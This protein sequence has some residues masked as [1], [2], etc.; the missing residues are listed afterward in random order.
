V[1]TADDLSE[2]QNVA[3]EAMCGFLKSGQGLLRV[4]GYAGT[5]KSTVTGVFARMAQKARLRV[6]YVAFT[7]RASSIVMKSLKNAGVEFTTKTREEQEAEQLGSVA[8][9]AYM[10]VDTM[11]RYAS[12]TFVG[13]IHRLLYKPIINDKEELIGWRKRDS[14][15]RPYDLIVVDEA[16]MVSDEILGDLQQFSTPIMAVG[17]HGQLPPVRAAGALMQKPDVRLEKIHRQAE[18]NPIIALAH[19]VR[20]GRR[21]SAFRSKDPRVAIRSKR[22][23]QAVLTETADRPPISIGVLCWTN[24]Q[25]IQLNMLARKARGFKGPPTT[26]EVLMCLRNYTR[27]GRVPIYNGMRGVLET[28]CETGSRPWY[29]NIRIGFPDEGVAAHGRLVCQAQFNRDGVFATVEEL[30][31][32]G[33]KVDTMGG[34]GEFFDFGYALTVHKSQGSQFNHAIVMVDMPEG[35]SDFARWAYTAVTRGQERVTVL[36]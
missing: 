32:R 2:D 3:F 4:G 23:V 10:D 11:D 31:Q 36:R 19:H 20:E 5:G 22:D 25:R 14:L 13:T 7:G 24:K 6:A 8:A 29:L 34:A 9:M 21:L 35:Y 15:D 26:S 1:I 28:K 27:G 33:I 30:H 16:S 18:G 12:E 17:D